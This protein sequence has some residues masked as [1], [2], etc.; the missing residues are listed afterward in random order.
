MKIWRQFLC[1]VRC[2]GPLAGELEHLVCEACAARYGASPSGVPILM[3]PED[4]IRFREVLSRDDGISMKEQYTRRT[5]KR[6]RESLLRKLYPP[7]P[8]YVNPLAPPLP[9]PKGSL[10]LW[11]G[12]AGLDLP[13]F[14]NLDLVPV[15]GVD[16]LANA[17]RLPFRSN[18]C[19]SIACLA[20]LEHV[21]DSE[22]VVSEMLRVL[23]PQG[24]VQAVVPFC[25]PYHGYPT[26]YSRFSREGLMKLFAGY[27]DVRIGIRTGPTT[28]ILTFLTYY[29]KLI[30][31]VHGGIAPVRWF[32]RIVVGAAGWLMAPLKYI[33]I[34]LNKSPNAHV[35]A[36]HLY[37][38]ARKPANAS[39]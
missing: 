32:N 6:H 9:Q 18:C 8:V 25:H 13:G 23:K 16:L 3:T 7:E 11:L 4:Q 19:D 12:G 10:S 35:L 5:T 37:V 31:P 27:D 21:P 33:D 36:N 2:G 20:L 22:Q 38:T 39:H 17:A 34:V 1:C 24:E 14:V 29:A 28:T 15:R 30:F 26:D